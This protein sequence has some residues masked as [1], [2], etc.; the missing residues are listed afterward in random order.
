MGNI[1]RAKL[2]AEDLHLAIVVSRF[3][4][5]ITSQLL[6]G[7]IDALERLSASECDTDVYWVPGSFELPAAAR[8]L[9]NSG[10]YDGVLALGA[11]IRGDTD[12]YELLAAE[13]TKGLAQVNLKSDVPLSFGVLT[14]DTLEQALHRAG[15]KAGNKGAEAMTSLIE[16]V[17]LNVAMAGEPEEE[18][19][20]NG[21]TPAT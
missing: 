14:C 6:S 9:C 5:L 1:Y 17:N 4:E 7:A 8:R 19:D 2:I 15:T 18:E 13:V 16:M 11:L 12:H 20:S 3:N 10:R 21:T